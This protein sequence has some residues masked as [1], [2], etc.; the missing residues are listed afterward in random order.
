MLYPEY[1]YRTLMSTTLPPLLWRLGLLALLLVVVL[2]AGTAAAIAL[3]ASDPACARVPLTVVE[4]AVTYLQT[5]PYA[6]EVAA[7]NTGE[8]TSAWGV[9]VGEFT[10]L[11][12]SDGYV[13]T[14]QDGTRDWRQF[15]HI[16]SGRN[17]L[18]V[19]IAA[20]QEAILYINREV[21]WRGQLTDVTGWTV[22]T[23]GTT[24]MTWFS[25]R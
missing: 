24:R 15:R 17:A 3:G 5:S 9:Q 23:E 4:P 2:G 21:A 13:S 19:V 14:T 1:D 16:R 25:A 22:V 8:F 10:A 12:T 20:D 18:C 6:F 7:S 11:I